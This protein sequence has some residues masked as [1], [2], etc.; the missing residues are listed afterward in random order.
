VLVG[1]V[2][3]L[4]REKQ[5]ERLAAV[6]RIPGVSVVIVGDGP[7]R[8]WLERQLP[9]AHFTCFRRGA[10]LGRLMASLDVFAR[11][12]LDETFCQAAQEAMAAGVAGV[13][14]AAGGPRDLVQHGITDLLWS[15]E[16]PETLAGAVRELVEDPS[17]RG[18]QADAGRL[19]VRGRT[20]PVVLDEAI[21]HY[22]HLLDQ[23]R[24]SA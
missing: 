19:S 3:R 12:G 11:T 10:A 8:R 20:W 16:A 23:G 17:L 5:V 9:A 4:A 7:R 2:G 13:A 18:R 21:G 6:T 15:P 24:L 22:V 1:Y 14:P